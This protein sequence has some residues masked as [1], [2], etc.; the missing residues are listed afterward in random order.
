[1]EKL[2]VETEPTLCWFNGKQNMGEDHIIV[3]LV[4][5]LIIVRKLHAHGA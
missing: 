1:M 5:A 2:S 4:T 3:T